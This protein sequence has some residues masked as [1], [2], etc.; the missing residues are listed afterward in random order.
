MRK[1]ILSLVCLLGSFVLLQAQ[2][3]QNSEASSEGSVTVENLL[4]RLDA[5]GTVPG[6][7][8]DYFTPYEQR[9]LYVHYNGIQ[10]MAQQ[11]ITQSNSKVMEAVAG[12]VCAPHPIVF[13]VKI[14]YRTFDF[15]ANFVIT[16]GF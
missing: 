9:M 1:I 13:R 7:V 8:G 14:F 11:L 6:S 10:N 15:L 5:I 4:E 2:T 12:F 16:N 3:F